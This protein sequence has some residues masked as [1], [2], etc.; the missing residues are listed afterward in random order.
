MTMQKRY[1]EIDLT[2]GMAIILA[3]FGH[4]APD[5]VKGFW[6][7]GTDSLSASLH[8]L[9][10]SFH[11][12]LFF[13]CSGFLL[14]PKFSMTKGVTDVVLKRFK[15]IMIPYFFLSFVYLFGK[16]FGGSL[17]DHQLTDN[18]FVGI[19]FGSS[20]CF[21]AWFLWCLF[22]MTLIVLCLRWLN[23]WLLFTI[24]IAISYIPVEYGE[25]YMGV[26]KVQSGTMWLILGCIVRKYYDKISGN[27]TI[28]LGLL[29]ALILIALHISRGVYDYGNHLVNHTVDMI[30]TLS[31]IV[32]SF[33][34]C[35]MIAYKTK[36]SLSYKSLKICGEYC[37]DIYI[38]SMFILV[39]L[40]VLYVN[41][42][43]MNIIPYYVWLLI[44]TVLG[45]T[46]PLLLSKI[47]VRKVR[48]LRLL[49]LGG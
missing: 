42:G 25:N 41:G 28:W 13:A 29:A 4:A 38:I 8:Y 16:M 14:Y 1:D 5:A 2:K 23:L 44:A 31:G 9:V 7:V 20:P 40:R 11:M 10:Y 6:I 45:V 47:V 32:A 22:V 27:V 17:A 12:A 21:G 30:K 34:L 36:D 33:T 18:P 39:S 37:M 15:K 49:I 35:Y 46:L 24:F 3:V 26:A 43:L 48:W 19:M